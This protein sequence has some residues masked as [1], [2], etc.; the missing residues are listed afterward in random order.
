AVKLKDGL[1]VGD[2]LAAQ[3]LEFVVANK[4]TRIINCAGRQVPNHWESIGVAYLTYYW[5]DADS[6]VILDQRDVVANETFSFVE[7]ALEAAESVLIHSVRG[8]SRSCCILAA[9]MMKKYSWGLRKTMEFLSSRRPDLELKPAF[10]Q[11]LLGFER[12]LMSQAKTVFSAD[13]N[14]GCNTNRWECEEL[15]LRNTYIN[16][17][18]GPLAEIQLEAPGHHMKSQRL[19][20]MDAGMDD[21]LRLEKP[22]GADR[23]NLQACKRDQPGAELQLVSPFPVRLKERAA[24]AHLHPEAAL[25]QRCPGRVLCPGGHSSPKTRHG[26]GAEERLDSATGRAESRESGACLCKKTASSNS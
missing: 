4:V 25:A 17:Q 15:L 18:M 22:P 13:W 6:Q 16:S 3:D 21:R 19:V 7:Q 11:Q 24:G 9:Y 14:D 2:E 12:R 23:I 1:F 10:L 8:Q 26:A 20:W 5:I